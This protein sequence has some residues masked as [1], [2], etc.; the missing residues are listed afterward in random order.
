MLA[1]SEIKK[2]ELLT[3]EAA[4]SKE[5]TEYTNNGMLKLQTSKHQMK[6]ELEAQ[7][8]RT[9]RSQW[10]LVRVVDR[11][12]QRRSHALARRLVFD[13]PPC[14]AQCARTTVRCRLSATAQ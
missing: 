6:K 9:R 2:E 3:I 11:G 8:M 14:P 13:T 12:D 1:E 4:L 7:R 5:K 10:R